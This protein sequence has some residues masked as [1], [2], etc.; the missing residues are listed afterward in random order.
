[1]FAKIEIITGDLSV[2]ARKVGLHRIEIFMPLRRRQAADVHAGDAPLR[3]AQQFQRRAQW[4]IDFVSS[5]NSRGFHA[6]IGFEHGKAS[7]RQID[8]GDLFADALDALGGI[9]VLVC[10]AGFAYYG[11]VGEAD[12]DAIERIYRLMT[13]GVTGS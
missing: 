5:E 12:W 6:D 1:M 9:D 4:R 8:G 2:H 13:Q 3:D 10:N 7:R 11:P